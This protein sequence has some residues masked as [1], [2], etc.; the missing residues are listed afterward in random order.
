MTTAVDPPGTGDQLS[1]SGFGTQVAAAINGFL[2]SAEAD[3]T[4]TL[5]TTNTQT[6]VAGCSISV[7]VTGSKAFAW[8]SGGFD[9]KC[10]VA[11]A[12]GFASGRLLVDG[13]AATGTCQFGTAVV[14]IEVQGCRIWKIPL[15]AGAH[16]L[17]LQANSSGTSV[18]TVGTVASSIS[19]I[20]FD[21]Q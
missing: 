19:A 9:W 13:V 1:S 11:Q 10:T 15:T 18:A 16:T 2:L 7:T 6:D 8:V 12:G 14:N 4:L 5:T 17:K 21:L 20:I 3:A